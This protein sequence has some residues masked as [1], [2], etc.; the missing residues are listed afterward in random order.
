MFKNDAHVSIIRLVLF[1]VLVKFE[2]KVTFINTGKRNCK[3]VSELK[4]HAIETYH[5]LN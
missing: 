3:V 2:R 5:L 1:K 4:Y